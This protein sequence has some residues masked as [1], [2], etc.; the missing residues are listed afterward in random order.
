MF[1]SGSMNAD[2][3]T[4]FLTFRS[5]ILLSHFT[6]VSF[7]ITFVLFALALSVY[8]VIRFLCEILRENMVPL[9]FFQISLKH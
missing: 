4:R 2:H 5:A 8:F 9:T 3:A 6:L 7:R 1:F